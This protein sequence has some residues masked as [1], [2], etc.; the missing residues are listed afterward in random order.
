MVWRIDAASGR[1]VLGTTRG[2]AAGSA[3]PR[4]PGCSSLRARSWAQQRCEDPA[5]GARSACR[6]GRIID[7]RRHPPD[8]G[9]H[10]QGRSARPPRGPGEHDGHGHQGQRARYQE[11]RTVHQRRRQAGPRPRTLRQLGR[12][13]RA[14]GDLQRELR[15]TAARHGRPRTHGRLWRF[16]QRTESRGGRLRGGPHGPDRRLRPRALAPSEARSNRRHAA[17]SVHVARC[18]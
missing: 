16:K 15:R 2:T 3:L 17:V 6:E 10:R 13:A 9:I 18:G 8:R 11:L 14:P 4:E 1:Q 5:C 7:E 12:R